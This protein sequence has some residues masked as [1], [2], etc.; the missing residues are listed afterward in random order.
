M[1]TKYENHKTMLVVSYGFVVV[2]VGVA[3]VLNLFLFAYQRAPWWYMWIPTC[4]FVRGF[5]LIQSSF[6]NQ[7]PITFSNMTI[8][9]EMW[10]VFAWL[11]AQA[12][13]LAIFA[14]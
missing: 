5:Y 4:T 13:V 9:N 14:M 3:I 7:P 1:K 2:S 8:H 6:V 10:V 11:I 12:I